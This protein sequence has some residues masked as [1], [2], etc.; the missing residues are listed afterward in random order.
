MEKPCIRH[1]LY[2]SWSYPQ[3]N[4]VLELHLTKLILRGH[5]MVK[6][7]RTAKI[8]WI[9]TIFIILITSIG[10]VGT[11]L[12]LIFL[13]V[14]W[15]TWLLASI[16]G[17]LSGLG[18]TGGYHRLC[19]HKSYKA[20]WPIRLLFAL[21]AA[22]AFQGSVI[23]WSSDHRKHH[24]FTDTDNDP[25][26][27]KKGF[28][29]AH[30]GWLFTLD[31]SKRDFSNVAD[32]L[33]DPIYHFQHKFFPMIGVIM[34][35]L[36]PTGIAALW[37]NALGGLVVAA[38]L[39]I[40]IVY[41]MTFFINSI[42]HMFGDQTYKSSTARDN[43]FTAL[44]T[45]GEGYHNFHHQFPIDYRNGVKLYHFDPTKWL[46]FTLSCMGL[47]SDLRRVRQHQIVKYRIQNE[48]K[49]A[50]FSADEIVKPLSERIHQLLSYYEELE[51]SL[52]SLKKSRL[53]EYRSRITETKRKLRQTKRELRAFLSVWGQLARS[54][55]V[56]EQGA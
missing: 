5:N 26:N 37:G 2:D 56:L 40:S 7:E 43:W 48:T 47:A 17:I 27:I 53:K 54:N 20:P 32:L 22:A 51:K 21:F 1:P 34:G 4:Y 16:M 42:C 14:S 11:P 9:N 30:I 33:Q 52:I 12:L 49:R 6:R 10:F 25:Y 31:K 29:H 13:H 46:I 41:Q 45:F 36:L 3:Q 19:A 23:E 55:G 50:N 18:I 39:R 38:A 24:R 8:N 28:W 44:F 15:A 35:I